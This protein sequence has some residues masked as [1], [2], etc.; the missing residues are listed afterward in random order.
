MKLATSLLLLLALAPVHGDDADLL[1]QALRAELAVA[2][3]G[4]LKVE[5]FPSSDSP[6]A[7][8]VAVACDGAG[9]SRREH[10]DGPSAGL[11]VIAERGLE[12]R[13]PR[14]ATAWQKVITT[15]Q[16]PEHEL[17]EVDRILA[18]YHLRRGGGR[19]VCGRASPQ[20][21]LAPSQAGNPSRRLWIDNGTRLV[22]VAEI[23]NRDRQIIGRTTHQELRYTPP[24]A[25]TVRLPAGAQVDDSTP[26]GALIQVASLAELERRL[27]RAPLQPTRVPTG[28]RL[29]GC[30]LR[31]CAGGG[32]TPVTTW[33]NGLN[34]LTLMETAGRGRGGGQGRG[35]R[36][37][38]GRQQCQITPSRLQI[39]VRVTVEGDEAVL[40]GDLAKDQMEAMARGLE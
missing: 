5:V 17:A 39:V 27:G 32:W 28:Y 21:D 9:R 38:W 7:S 34:S 20:L 18:N 23:W 24:A 8:T 37:R 2:R 6:V 22:L 12:Y 35:R 13:R 33:S 40:V 15:G 25:A 31:A 11:L 4:V 3:Q 19:T 14:G 29:S 1:R 30:Y 16:S 26:P 10:R 36:W